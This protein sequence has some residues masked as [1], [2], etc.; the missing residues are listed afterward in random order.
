[1]DTSGVVVYFFGHRVLPGGLS[2]DIFLAFLPLVWLFLFYNAQ[3]KKSKLRMT[4]WGYLWIM[5][6]PNTVYLILE[7][8]HIILTDNVADAKEP[9]AVI[10]FAL[11]SLLGLILTLY[12]IYSVAT[13]V[14]FMKRYKAIGTVALSFMAT[15]GS[16]L[17]LNKLNSI[18]GLLFP[19]SIVTLTIKLLST[20]WLGIALLIGSVLSVLSFLTLK[21]FIPKRTKSIKGH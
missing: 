13:K 2:V 7:Y 14:N 9:I 18:D 5:Y 4:L 20:K 3:K 11:I 6:F 21:F 10:S 17:G 16:V 15:W 12:Q 8:R 19:L 1:M